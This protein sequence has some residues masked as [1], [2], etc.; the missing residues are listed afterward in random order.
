M[1]NLMSLSLEATK[2]KEENTVDEFIS[3]TNTDFCKFEKIHKK[4]GYGCLLKTK[5]ANIEEIHNSEEFRVLLEKMNEY[6]FKAHNAK[7]NF[8]CIGYDINNI[9]K[10]TLKKVDL[11]INY[12]RNFCQKIA[13]KEKVFKFDF[14]E[15]RFDVLGANAS[16]R[17]PLVWNLD[18]NIVNFVFFRSTLKFET[19]MATLEYVKTLFD[20]FQTDVA[21]YDMLLENFG[22]LFESYISYIKQN[23]TYFYGYLEEKY[24]K[25]FSGVN[26]SAEII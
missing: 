20:F 19:I 17:Y 16:N 9:N 5:Y 21:T 10:S 24:G 7:N 13:R 6:G 14:A 18:N 15:K 3:N 12:T 8:M 2:I 23:T 4:S 25:G 11:F 26:F 1:A 22:G